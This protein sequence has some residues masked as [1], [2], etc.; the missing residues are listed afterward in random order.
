MSLFDVKARRFQVGFPGVKNVYEWFQLRVG[1]VKPEETQVANVRIF[2]P[3]AA[4]YTFRTVSDDGIKLYIDGRLVIDHDGQHAPASK[5]GSIELTAGYHT[6]ALDYF[7]GPRYQIALELFWLADQ[8]N[9]EYELSTSN[10][11]YVPAKAFYTDPQEIVVG[12]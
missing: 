12:L 8:A 10:Y 3:V 6:F 7:Q 1:R 5:T 11:K 9:A 2:A 4:K